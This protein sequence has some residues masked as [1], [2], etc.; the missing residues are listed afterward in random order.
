MKLQSK[1]NT[2]KQAPQDG[3]VCAPF[4][5]HMSAQPNEKI[6]KFEKELAQKT[7]EL[8]E[9]RKCKEEALAQLENMVKVT[10]PTTAS[11]PTPTL[12]VICFVRLR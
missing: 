3:E 1:Q 2:S 10:L 9:E 5:S 7:H 12:E 4:S 6:V 11:M 8:E